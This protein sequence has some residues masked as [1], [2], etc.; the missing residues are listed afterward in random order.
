MGSTLSV[1]TV[2][3]IAL[4]SGAI[5]YGF[6][7]RRPPP[8]EWNAKLADDKKSTVVSFPAVVP[9]S[10][11]T[12]EPTTKQ[13]SK[14][15][16][17]KKSTTAAPA[18]RSTDDAQSDSSA[19]APEAHTPVARPSTSK[20]S[21]PSILDGDGQWT[22]VEPRKRNPPQLPT[23]AEGSKTAATVEASITSVTGT[24]SPTA[25][26]TEDEQQPPLQPEKNNRRP[27]AERLL[28]KPRKTGVDDM[29]ETP[30]V[31]TLA[32]VMRVQP[33]PDEKPAVGFSWGDYEDVDEARGTA[34][35]ADG[36]DDEGGWVVKSSSKGRPKATSTPS[37][38]SLSTTS[39][40]ELSKKQRQNSAKQAAKKAT[41]DEIEAERL[42][43]LARHK[44][45]L[46]KA[47]IAEQYAGKKPKAHVTD[48]GHLAFE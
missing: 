34:D 37:H 42:A 11:D 23:A 36:E 13:K 14:K 41:K 27:L 44:R 43:R 5:A 22:R 35:D 45:E 8:P 21:S 29:L 32:R 17:P 39:A 6:L 7:E 4:I 18:V 30:D 12:P 9:G 28:P 20:R 24:S 25:D 33:K 46:E 38:T 3:S 47:R 1:P 16:K 40:A 15:K 19:T 31:P 26:P 2:L 10:F 48:K